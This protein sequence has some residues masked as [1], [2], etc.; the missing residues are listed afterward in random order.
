MFHFFTKQ[1]S[2]ALW[3]HIHMVEGKEAFTSWLLWLLL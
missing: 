1:E 3:P 2:I